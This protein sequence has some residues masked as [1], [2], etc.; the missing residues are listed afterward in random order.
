MLAQL[1]LSALLVMGSTSEISSVYIKAL[2][3]Y[4]SKQY[5]QAI[6]Q[7]R[8]VLPMLQKLQATKT[9]QSKPWHA[10]TL[11]QCDVLFHLGQSLWHTGQKRAA[12]RTYHSLNTKLNTIPA[13]W[14]KWR[15][16][17]DLPQRIQTARDAYQNL[18]PQV[19]SKLTVKTTPPAATVSWRLPTQDWKPMPN[20]TLLL[21]QELVQIRVQ[22]PGFLTQ[23]R[24]KVVVQRWT[25]KTL[26]V[27]LKPK[28]IAAKRRI[29]PPPK[30]P[31]PK[32]AWY[33]SPWLW[34]GV[35]A[36]VI[37]GATTATLL[38]TANTRETL[39]GPNGEAFK[40]W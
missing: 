14:N 17:P 36:A 9:P 4:R 33:Q 31:Q 34:I 15:I 13:G 21:K 27:A 5:T 26:T 23:T 29:T 28:P 24:D 22:A 11:G 2:R 10:V 38:L 39:K 6:P 37:A 7:L 8:K 40:L 19:S 30:R 20:N 18:C 1:A 3:Q 35:G 25:Q 32:A 12:C 16:H